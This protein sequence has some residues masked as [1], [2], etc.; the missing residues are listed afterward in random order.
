MPMTTRTAIIAIPAELDPIKVDLDDVDVAS[1]N[2][3][4]MPIILRGMLAI[5]VFFIKSEAVKRTLLADNTKRTTT[6]MPRVGNAEIH[7]VVNLCVKLYPLRP[8]Y[9]SISGDI[10]IRASTN[11]AMHMGKKI[12]FARFVRIL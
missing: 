8:K 5:I 12:L 4:T 7:M 6:Y 11:I 1:K 2:D 3:T 9:E 10:K